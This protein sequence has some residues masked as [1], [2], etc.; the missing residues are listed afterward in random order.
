MSDAPASGSVQVTARTV[1]VT[2]GA[3]SGKSL[4]AEG[5]VNASQRERIY[6][7]TCTPFDDEMHQRID[8][9]RDQRGEGWRTIEE[10]RDLAGVIAAESTEGRAILIDCLTLWLSNLI[11]AE[12]DPEAETARLAGALRAAPGPV[13]LVTN[14]V[15]SGIVPDNALARRFRD[16]QGRLNRRIAELAD[17]AVLVAAGL[18]LVLKPSHLQPEISL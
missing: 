6:V 10:P 9:H 5:L 15:G 2:G 18:P 13:V 16:E 3:R 1:L 8:R 11:F 17:V 14:E 4:Y 7:A 12:A